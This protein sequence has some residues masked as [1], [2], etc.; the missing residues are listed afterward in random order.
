M[1]EELELETTEEVEE[2]STN[3]ATEEDEVVAVGNTEEE[4]NRC[5]TCESDRCPCDTCHGDPKQY[6]EGEDSAIELLGE[7]GETTGEIQC[8]DCEAVS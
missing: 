5:A 1:S 8:P 2:E 6:L 3:E 4:S 7:N